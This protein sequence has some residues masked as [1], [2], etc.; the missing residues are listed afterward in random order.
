MDCF[1]KLERLIAQGK[2][3]FDFHKTNPRPD[4]KNLDDKILLR[5]TANLTKI[6]LSSA[7]KYIS[8]SKEDLDEIIEQVI[9]GEQ[10]V[11][12]FLE[13][14]YHSKWYLSKAAAVMQVSKS[15]DSYLISEQ[16]SL[17]QK[18]LEKKDELRKYKSDLTAGV[19]IRAGLDQLAADYSAVVEGAKRRQLPVNKNAAANFSHYEQ[20][21]KRINDIDEKITQ[22]SVE[23]SS[24]PISNIKD[25]KAFRDKLKKEKI[26][27]K[28]LKQYCE[29]NEY[30]EGMI[31]VGQLEN[32]V[33]HTI[34]NFSELV[35][36]K[37]YVET[38][39]KNYSNLDQELTSIKSDLDRYGPSPELIKVLSRIQ[40][41]LK[42]SD[43]TAYPELKRQLN[44][45]L[46]SVVHNCI[47]TIDQ[48]DQ[49]D[50]EYVHSL[51]S[52]INEIKDV[53][54]K[55]RSIEFKK[56]QRQEAESYTLLEEKIETLT[57]KYYETITTLEKEKSQAEQEL[58]KSKQTSQTLAEELATKKSEVEEYK[59]GK[60]PLIFELEDFNIF[61]YLERKN[62]QPRNEVFKR[63]QGVLSRENSVSWEKRLKQLQDSMR[64][65]PLFYSSADRNFLG[66]VIFALE[67]SVREGSL[68][69][70]VKKDH[71][72]S[73]QLTSTVD[74]LY[75]YAQQYAQLV[76]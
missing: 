42:D 38:V 53:T 13:F 8:G 74:G 44:S 66:D 72:L 55:I 65:S 9:T 26:E 75:R 35:K 47:I 34:K 14:E 41:T 64:Q 37:E 29:E 36:E 5:I 22:L 11:N 28:K 18:Y 46:D 17:N 57:G 76:A 62:H 45:K 21:R 7:E 19:K 48:L 31:K 67:T 59:K 15:L 70:F 40:Q 69:Y 33:D 50:L 16:A 52:A 61:D 54:H 32:D 30:Y 39:R 49:E 23:Y 43:K 25:W 12:E 1:I 27:G 71:K 60:H 10:A 20:A 68:G 6:D 2:I 4:D 73:H 24:L 3:E 51:Y 58:N 63:M 56:E